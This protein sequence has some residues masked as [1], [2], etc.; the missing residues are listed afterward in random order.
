MKP[1]RIRQRTMAFPG[2]NDENVSRP[3]RILLPAALVDQVAP[4]A[5]RD[6]DASGMDM[7]IDVPITPKEPGFANQRNA[8]DSIGFKRQQSAATRVIPNAWK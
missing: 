2:T 6:L 7:G 8:I 4:D 1:L 3:E 5:K